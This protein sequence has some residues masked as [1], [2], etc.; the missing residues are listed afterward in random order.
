LKAARLVGEDGLVIAL[1]PELENYKL[2]QENV[3]LNSLENIVP[4][5][6]A[7]SD[8]Q[9]PGKLSLAAG[10]IAHSLIFPRSNDWQEV[11]VNTMDGLIEELGFQP[12][13]MK[14]DVEGAALNILARAEKMSCQR[15][16]VA[17]YHFPMEEVQVSIKL[18]NLGFKTEIK[19]V[20]ARSTGVRSSRM[21][22]W[23]WDGKIRKISMVSRPNE[24]NHSP[25]AQPLDKQL[26][27]P[28]PLI[29]YSNFRKC[30]KQ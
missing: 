11:E 9:G 30:Y 22:R 20:R 7:L 27:R 3:K 25:D 5:P 23:F 8:F 1:E 26:K 28:Q 10:T 16:V 13:A 18:R 14:I 4:L 19:Q 21:C 15:I 17:A 2:L 29:T 6:M 12:Y 24:K